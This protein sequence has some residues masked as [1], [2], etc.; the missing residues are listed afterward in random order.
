MSRIEHVTPLTSLS[1]RREYFRP[2]SPPFHS[3]SHA[4]KVVLSR[5]SAD[6]KRERKKTVVK[7]TNEK[8]DGWKTHTK[9]KE[10]AAGRLGCRYALHAG[11]SLPFLFFF[12]FSFFRSQKNPSLPPSSSSYIYSFEKEEYIITS[13]RRNDEYRRSRS[14]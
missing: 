11:I 8:K 9:E 13:E 4:A 6:A 7:C 3:T 10:E 2:G 12:S 1:S 5:L 14:Y